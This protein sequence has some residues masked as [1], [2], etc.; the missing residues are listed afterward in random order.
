M[1]LSEVDEL[2]QEME[3]T[4]LELSKRI[5]ST[6]GY[7]YRNEPLRPILST[8]TTD[9]V[10]SQEKEAQHK[11]GAHRK[12]DFQS[13]KDKDTPLSDTLSTFSQKKTDAFPDML[14]PYNNSFHLN[15]KIISEFKTWERN[16]QQPTV[17]PNGYTIDK[18]RDHSINVSSTI[19]NVKPRESMA[20]S[21]ILMTDEADAS[22]VY[23]Q[24]K[25]SI[26]NT[27]LISHINDSA[28]LSGMMPSKTVQRSNTE[29]LDLC[30]ISQRNETLHDNE[31]SDFGKSTVHVATNTDLNLRYFITIFLH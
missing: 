20:E 4:E 6:S 28:K 13:W 23:I 27:D 30:K 26:T 25:S 10:S 15:D 8:Q 3:A 18:N 9:N 16:L 11:L 1:E 19:D 29:P 17:K 7:Q 21:N 31:K 24:S 14:L 2:L 12:L 5:N 22:N